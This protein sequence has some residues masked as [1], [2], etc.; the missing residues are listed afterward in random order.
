MTRQ[1]RRDLRLQALACGEPDIG[2]GTAIVAAGIALIIILVP[3]FNAVGE[4]LT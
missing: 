4:S 3:L 2:T 1:D